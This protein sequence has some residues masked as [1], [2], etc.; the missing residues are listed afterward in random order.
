MFIALFVEYP[1][2]YRRCFL[3]C[4]NLLYTSWK[5]VVL[6][7]LFHVLDCNAIFVN[8]DLLPTLRPGNFDLHRKMPGS[9]PAWTVVHKCPVCADLLLVGRRSE[10]LCRHLVE[11]KFPDLCFILQTLLCQ[12]RTQ[13]LHCFYRDQWELI[14]AKRARVLYRSTREK[15]KRARVLAPGYEA[16]VMPRNYAQNGL[17]RLFK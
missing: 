4:H 2:E 14:N 5:T 11:L 1:E 13:A 10:R 6:L 8:Q 17:D 12:P 16:V 9:A 15:T 3:L 7:F